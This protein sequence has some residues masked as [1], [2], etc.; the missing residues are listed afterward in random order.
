MQALEKLNTAVQAAQQLM[1]HDVLVAALCM[2]ATA[3]EHL[4]AY[5]NSLLDYEQI[6]QLQACNIAVSVQPSA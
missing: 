1:G 3:Y 2:R 5:S 6:L 4:E